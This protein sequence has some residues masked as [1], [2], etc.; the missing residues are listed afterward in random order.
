MLNAIRCID[1]RFVFKKNQLQVAKYDKS[2]TVFF[3]QM[4]RTYGLVVKVSY[5]ESGDMG[6]IL[7][8]C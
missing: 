1:Q 8:K 7:D 6:S 4:I 3:K 5:R 2:Y